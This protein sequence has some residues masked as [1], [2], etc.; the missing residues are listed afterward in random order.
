MLRKLE[1]MILIKI[2]LSILVIHIRK[3]EKLILRFKI[4]RLNYKL[5]L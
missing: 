3:K 5:V 1:R 4:V 2:L